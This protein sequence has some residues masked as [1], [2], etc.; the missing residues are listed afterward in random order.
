MSATYG[1][2]VLVDGDN[3]QLLDAIPLQSVEGGKY[4]EAWLQDL[5]YH[6]PQSLPVTDI[7]STFVPVISVCKELSTPSGGYVDILLVTPQ[8]RLAV[9]EVKLWRN[10]QARREVIGQ[11]LEYA[12]DLSTWHYEGLDAAIRSARRNEGHPDGT[13]GLLD[14]AKAAWPDLE[15]KSFIDG[16]SSSMQRGDFLLLIVGDGIRHGVSAI[17]EFL[18]GHASL[19]FTF[20]I[21]EMPVFKDSAGR[22]LLQPRVH[23]QTLIVRRTVVSLGASGNSVA[24]DDE[25]PIETDVD[26]ALVESRR[27]FTAFWAEFLTNWQLDDQRQPMPRPARST[28]L[29]F[30]LP[31]ESKGWISAYVAKSQSR[32]GVYLTFE[33]GPVASKLYEGLLVQRTDIEKVIGTDVSW[34]TEGDDK[35]YVITRRS[36]PNVADPQSRGEIIAWLRDKTNRFVSAFRPRIEALLRDVANG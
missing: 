23:A 24:E 31:S 12:K 1:R 26:P 35:F 28:N 4:S 20:G 27:Y 17:A 34:E 14:V 8:G 18:D 10:P 22:F 19:H 11:L 30:Y 21:V 15:E 29:Y 2:P 32:V 3:A 5:L 7:E 33:R 36:F 25:S 6:H 13:L 9:V 16:V